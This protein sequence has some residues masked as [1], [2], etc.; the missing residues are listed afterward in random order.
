M[1]SIKKRKDT[2]YAVIYTKNGK[3]M[4]KTTGVKV[5]GLK[6]RKLAQAT[7]DSMEA[8]MKSGLSVDTAVAALRKHS[9]T[10]GLCKACPSVHQYLTE[11]AHEGRAKNKQA[12]AR[13]AKRFIDFLEVD[14]F[15]ALDKVNKQQCRA[16]L[17]AE[18]KRVTYGTVK[19]IRA[20]LSASFNAAKKDGIIPFNPF[21]GVSMTTLQ[22]ARER[23][24]LQR[25]PFTAEE[26][27]II[28][29]KFPYPY[30]ELAIVSF[31]TGGQRI[32]DIALLKWDCVDFENK[33]ISFRASK[34]WALIEAPITPVLEETLKNLPREQ[35]DTY[36]FPSAAIKHMRSPSYNST[37]FVSLL[38]AFGITQECPVAASPQRKRLSP[39]S[40]H[41]IRHTVVTMMRCNPAVSADLVRSIVGHDSEKVERAYF[42]PSI[43]AKKAGLSFLEEP[44]APPIK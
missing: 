19:H 14:A 11:H 37:E 35:G 28:T 43:E 30:R 6:E 10:L 21:D 9:E 38:K 29:T 33:I 26:M 17:E 12:Y 25:Q 42:S 18:L 36:V 13:Y 40:F 3:Y 4:T 41:S 23:I 15:R 20:I 8:V 24:I 16:F 32:S 5:K 2:W 44:I 7:A 27:R 22:P 31:L 39:K 34:T 1:A